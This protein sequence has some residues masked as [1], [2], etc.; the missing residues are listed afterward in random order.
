M[1]IVYP[2]HLDSVRRYVLAAH[3][4]PRPLTNREIDVLDQFAM[5][6]LDVIE[7]AWPVDTSLSRD[8]FTFSTQDG[9]YEQG[10]IGFTIENPI[11][12]AQYVHPAGTNPTPLY[13]YLFPA[14]VQ[15][16]APFYIGCLKAAI[17]RTEA[18]AKRGESL[19]ALIAKG[20]GRFV[21]GGASP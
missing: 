4:S 12:Y 1:S 14:V 18:E 3:G 2:V 13:T 10:P 8:S 16:M 21:F 7:E 5:A 9:D 15:E 20:A 19:V 6:A 17:D 11:W